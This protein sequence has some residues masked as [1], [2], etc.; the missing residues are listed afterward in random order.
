VNEEN[1]QK[2]REVVKEERRLRYENPPYGMLAEWVLDAT[3]EVVSR[4]S[5][6]RSGRWKT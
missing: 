6:R 2:E 3:F 5:A 1:F 4:T